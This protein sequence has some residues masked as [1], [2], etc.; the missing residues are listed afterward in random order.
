MAELNTTLTLDVVESTTKSE[1]VS[2]DG[3]KWEGRRLWIVYEPGQ[4]ITVE[5]EVALL[6]AGGDEIT[7]RRFTVPDSA[8]NAAAVTDLKGIVGKALAYAT[9]NDLLGAGTVS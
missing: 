5:V 3:A 4:G 6:T 7:R 1:P 2:Y 8:I 9:A